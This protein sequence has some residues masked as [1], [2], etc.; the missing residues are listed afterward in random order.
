MPARQMPKK[1]LVA[2]SFAG[3][4]RNL[5]RSIAEAVEHELGRGTM[6]FDEWFEHF[7]AGGDADL[8][9]QRLYS[10]QCELAVVCVAKRY[11]EKPWTK[12]E[13]AA[14]RARVM[15]LQESRVEGDRHRMLPIRVGE[16]E[17][18]GIL[19]NTIVPDVCA[20]DPNETAKLIIDR[21]VL[22]LPDLNKGTA[23]GYRKSHSAVF[24]NV[25]LLH[26]AQNSP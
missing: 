21:L 3:E 4:Q 23:C 18:E 12:A 14:I 2:F 22:I 8:K 20:R 26:S 15:R 5:V 11:G 6:F 10:E 16:G 9:L 17:I 25:T 19:F 7:T 1:F 13:H 24:T